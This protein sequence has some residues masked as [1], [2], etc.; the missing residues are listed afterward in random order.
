MRLDVMWR[1]DEYDLVSWWSKVVWV[2]VGDMGC[3]RLWR[4]EL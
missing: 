2:W 4:F 3:S 1:K